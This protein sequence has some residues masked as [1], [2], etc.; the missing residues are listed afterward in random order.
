MPP[1]PRLS[2]L[3]LPAWLAAA[4]AAA[5]PS[6]ELWHFQP[7]PG[8]AGIRMSEA[9]R[10]EVP[11]TSHW[12]LSPLQGDLAVIMAT[13]ETWAVSALLVLTGLLACLGRR[14]PET[15]GRRVAGVLVLLAIVGPALPRYVDPEGHG[16]M[17]LLSA[18]WFTTV[19]DSWGSTQFCLL[20]A[21]VL[22]LVASWAMRPA[23]LEK[24]VTP[25]ADTAWRRLAAILVDYLVA[26]VLLGAV[27]RPVAI[28]TGAY[29][30]LSL[31][32]EYGFLNWIGLFE[33]KA[34]PLRLAILPVLFLYFWVQHALWGRTLGKRLLRIRVVSAQP[35]GP[36]R[37]RRTALRALIFPL[38]VLVP[39][40]GP[41]CLIVD[42][43]WA[44]LDPD[45]RV[46]HDRWA[47]TA[48]ARVR[49]RNAQ[50]QP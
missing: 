47:G 21:A 50:P 34:E 39:G 30:L 10:S 46:L 31:D 44:L 7:Q 42:G 22:V 36:P 8:I 19:I 15:V 1:S 6:W 32:L 2:R 24:P 48:V 38:L 35:E 29:D 4:V 18:A 40:F 27:V 41:F 37:A 14:D 17:P 13:V 5:L 12:L 43:L 28:L 16:P 3:A 11:L 26:I 49:V 9:Y 20:T 25:R 23:D 33:D 45:G